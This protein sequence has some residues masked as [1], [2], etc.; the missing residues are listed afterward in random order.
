MLRH[1]TLV[2]LPV[3]AVEALQKE[4]EDALGTTEDARREA[5]EEWLVAAMAE[6]VHDAAQGRRP[7]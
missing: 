4:R 2:T 5:E 7:V 6:N 1:G 3:V